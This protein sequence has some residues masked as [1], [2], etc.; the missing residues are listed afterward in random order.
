MTIVCVLCA[1]YIRI[2]LVCDR[3]TI[4]FYYDEKEHVPMLPERHLCFIESH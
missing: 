2:V 4:W 1:V 3:L